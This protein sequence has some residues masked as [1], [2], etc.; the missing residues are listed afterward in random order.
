MNT[1]KVIALAQYF[2]PLEMTIIRLVAD[3]AK[4]GRIAQET[5]LRKE[6]VQRRILIIGKRL[7]EAYTNV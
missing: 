3:G 1:E 6:A 7:K 2:T 5:G 4:A